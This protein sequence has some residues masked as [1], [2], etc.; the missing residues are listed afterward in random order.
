M[1][2]FV[3]EH[4]PWRPA[5]DFRGI[6]PIPGAQAVV[7][8]QTDIEAENFASAVERQH[9]DLPARKK[10]GQG[11]LGECQVLGTLAEGTLV[12]EARQVER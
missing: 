7:S 6:A 1:D 5:F 8:N 12:P 11:H 9:H 10:F 4:A 2:S 3:D